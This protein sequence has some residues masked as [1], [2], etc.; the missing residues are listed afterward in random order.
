MASRALDSVRICPNTHI[1]NTDRTIHGMMF[2]YVRFE[3]RFS[4]E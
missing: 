3:V 4:A 1:N 2:V